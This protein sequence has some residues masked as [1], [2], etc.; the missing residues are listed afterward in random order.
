[1]PSLTTA[2]AV[3]SRYGLGTGYR[4]LSGTHALHIELEEKIAQFKGT[5]A[6]VTFSSA[7]AAN[8][9]AV[10]TILVR[11]CCLPVPM[12]CQI[13]A[14]PAIPNTATRSQGKEDIVVSDQLNHASIIDAIRVA[15][16]KNKFAYAHSDMSDLEA[17]LR[18]ASE[19][20]KQPKTNGEQPLILVRQ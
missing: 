17:K 4:T 15:G 20:Q 1:M 14:V 16:V 8:A 3:W 18:A 6:A 5:E 12:H 19:L 10:Q 2:L 7:Y 13:L 9:S 11:P